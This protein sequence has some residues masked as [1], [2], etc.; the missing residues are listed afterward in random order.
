MRSEKSEDSRGGQTAAVVVEICRQS[1]VRRKLV[2][3]P[4]NDEP[5]DF[6]EL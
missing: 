4:T 5:S 6:R 3:E 1:H 2:S